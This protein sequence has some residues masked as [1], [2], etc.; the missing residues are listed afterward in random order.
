ML[1]RRAQWYDIYVL[2]NRYMDE[3]SWQPKIP[4]ELWMNSQSAGYMLD[5]C[6]S[7]HVEPSF[8]IWMHKFLS[9]RTV[10]CLESS[11]FNQ[12]W[13]CLNLWLGAERQNVIFAFIL[14][15]P[16]VVWISGEHTSM[17]FRTPAAQIHTKSTHTA[18]NT[19]INTHRA[20][21]WNMCCSLF[22]PYAMEYCGV[23]SLS[24]NPTNII[25]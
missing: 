23:A 22:V 25:W 6:K 4:H 21:S 12:Q 1:P 20:R 5:L 15:L 17:S 16:E 24:E 9:P 8:R 11:P 13:R 10:S 19:V 7:F 2:V 14:H 18:T 3:L